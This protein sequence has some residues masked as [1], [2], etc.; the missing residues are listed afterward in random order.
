MRV[1]AQTRICLSGFYT[2]MYVRAQ[3][4][5]CEWR[6]RLGYACEGSESDMRV[7]APDQICVSDSCSGMYVRTPTRYGL[8]DLTRICV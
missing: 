6:L 1:T 4:R 3:T 7:G 5:I 8:Y 2:E